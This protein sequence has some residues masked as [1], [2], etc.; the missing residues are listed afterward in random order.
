MIKLSR[1]GEQKL[2]RKTYEILTASIHRLGNS[3]VSDLM[4]TAVEI[5][6]EDIKGKIIGREGRNIKVFEKA[7]GVE[8]IIDEKEGEITLS[9]FDPLRREIAK[10]ALEN[11]IRDGRIQPAKIEEAIESADKEVGRLL[12]KKGEE[13]VFEVGLINIDESLYPILGR[14]YFRRSYV[15]NVLD[16][17]VEMAHIAGMLAAELG[18]DVQIAKAGALLHDIGKAISHEVEGTHVEIGR[19]ILQK[20]GVDERVI[21]AM[22]SHHEEYPYETLESII[23]QVADA[24]SGGRPGA[25]RDTL[26]NYLKRLGDLEKIALSFEGAQKAFALSAG[27]ELRIFVSPEEISD[28][29]AYKMARGIA[30]QIERELNYPG[31]IKINVIRETRCI[32]FAR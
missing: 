5:P 27:R 3:V 10:T 12:R 9:S 28:M 7:S 31:E 4:T 23:V 22:Q 29:D 18:G 26:E 24:I 30:L 17:S 19:R 6:D 14:L 32:T 8:V 20:F 11:L 16:H 21:Q 2:M 1:E 13:A 25:R 15:Q